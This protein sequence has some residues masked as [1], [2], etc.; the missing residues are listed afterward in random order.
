MRS[1]SSA[2]DGRGWSPAQ[3]PY[4][5][6]SPQ[7]GAP[8]PGAPQLGAPQLA[9]QQPAPERELP[10]GPEVSWPNGFRQMDFDSGEYRQ[11]VESSYA[12]SDYGDAGYG[13]PGY[14]DPRY[15]G[16]GQYSG[17]HPGASRQQ[18]AQDPVYPVTGAQE[19]YREPIPEPGVYRDPELYGELEVY[20][21]P[22]E[23][24][25]EQPRQPEPRSVD[26]RLAG[27]RY[28]ELHYDDSDLDAGPRYGEPRY[29]EPLDDD[30]WYA[31]LRRGGPA[32]PQSQP[33]GGPGQL[34]SGAGGSSSARP[35]EFPYASGNSAPG[36][37]GP[38]NA[39]QANGGPA[40]SGHAG[41]NGSSGRAAGPRMS[42]GPGSGP[43]SAVSVSRGQGR[44]PAA[45]RELNAAQRPGAQVRA[46][47]PHRRVGR[48]LSAPQGLT[49]PQRVL[50]P[51]VAAAPQGAGGPQALSGTQGFASPQVLPATQSFAAPQAAALQDRGF[52]GA[53]T[54]GVLM[55]PAGSQFDALPD[56][57][58]LESLEVYW[59]EDSGDA[60]YSE[61]LE[62]LDVAVDSPRRTVFQAKTAG[63]RTA[64][65]S[66][67]AP[68]IGRRR[69]RSSDHRLWL[70]LGGVVIVAVLA[71]FAIIKFEF[72]ASSGPAHTFAT[73][74]TIGSYQRSAHAVSRADLKAVSAELIKMSD[75][76]ATDAVA[77]AYESSIGPS[78][79]PATEIVLV[80]EAHL[81]NDSP[82]SSVTAF[83]QTYPDA[84]VVSAGPLGGE[85]VCEESGTGT[86]STAMCAWFDNNS[87]G[88]FSSATMPATELASVMPQLR[89]GL[90]LVA[91]G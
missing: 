85:A 62:E 55:P 54:V 16:H 38:G 10:Y 48:G 22:D 42:A 43:G 90:E 30:A 82:A 40:S 27:L 51:Q 12:E 72:P 28:D 75:G 53:P 81:A 33:P 86:D 64:R 80:S 14:A 34:P 79:T 61:L 68:G 69:G 6:R 2:H 66:I 9:A 8:K 15:D 26:P 41:T 24:R 18:P 76:Q 78:G 36:N 84:K 21:A 17:P 83:K 5:G 11:L 50:G 39:G 1:G 49:G 52:L 87:F 25:Y 37:A 58:E 29:D 77:A 45:P 13:D 57:V 65:P 59:Q 23:P 71:I 47:L 88:T 7:P 44:Q 74:S 31:E 67:S 46:A 3:H 91:K 63:P 89:Q 56:V 70:G 60:E 73:P 20:R 35:G 32:F 4:S 19:I